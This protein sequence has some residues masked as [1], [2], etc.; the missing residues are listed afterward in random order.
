MSELS[1]GDVVSQKP[2]SIYQA[3][4]ISSP[5]VTNESGRSLVY[6]FLFLLDPSTICRTYPGG[7]DFV[8][9]RA[10]GAPHGG[11][12]DRRET[13][14]KLRVLFFEPPQYDFPNLRGR[15]SREGR[16]SYFFSCVNLMPFITRPQLITA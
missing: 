6:K 11:I 4:A 16:K 3:A 14:L 1:R 15:R 13:G 8:F 12:F 5:W 7:M 2:L 9:H 10:G